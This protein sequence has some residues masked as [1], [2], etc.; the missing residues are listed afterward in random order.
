MNPG[1]LIF[2]LL[3]F[4][5]V[6]QVQSQHLVLPPLIEE[7]IEEIVA[8]ADE[9]ADISVIIDDLYFL[10][11]NPLDLNQAG[12]EDLTRL[13]LLNDFQIA[14]LFEYVRKFGPVLSIFE[15]NY[16]EGFDPALVLKIAPF[17]TIGT[18]PA[19]IP[20][21]PKNIL[22]YGRHQIY[23]RIQQVLEEQR[24]YLPISDSA[25]AASPNSR[26]L[27]SP[28][29]IY[30]RYVFS[31]RNQVFWGITAE[32]D[33]G[34]E[35]FKGSNQGGYD[36]Y[37]AH[38]YIRSSGK[39]KRIA[40]GDYHARF[41]QGLVL[42]PGFSTGKTADAVNIKKN[43]RGLIR[44]SSTDENIFMRGAAATIG[45]GS[46]TDIT[47]FISRKTI[48]ATIL[49][50]DSA[51]NR[52]SAV[53]S[54]QNTGL[55]ATQSQ[56]ANKNSLGETIAGTNISWKGETYRSGL[57]ALYYTYDAPLLPA[58]RVYNQYEFKGK[59]NLVA[60]MDYRLYFRN[61]HFF[62]E[63]AISR[64]GGYGFLNGMI[65]N[66][67]PRAALAMMYRKYSKN[68]QSYFSN[69]L[70]ESTRNSNETGL[71]TGIVLLP[72]PKW[73]VSGFYDIFYFPWLR[74][75]AFTPTTGYEYLLL[76]EY[77]PARN[78]SMWWRIRQ[79]NKPVNA[80]VEE[81]LARQTEEVIN[82]SYR[83]QLNYRILSSLELR[84]RIEFVNYK[85][86]SQPA[87]T[88]FLVYQDV[89]FRLSKIPLSLSARLA[90]FETD[91]YNA[92]MYA[93]ENDVLYA[94]SIPAYYDRGTRSYINLSYSF[95]NGVDLWF[96]IA[97]T[98]LP[99]RT[100]IGSGLDEISGRTRTEVKLQA[101]ITF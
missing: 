35:F 93:Y 20:L 36:Y 52:V 48:D 45:I 7:I 29:K 1:R 12:V 73:K 88:G 46:K 53:S 84:N 18:G 101:R 42:W 80:P 38:L 34:E 10:W 78:L 40:I 16:I 75:G 6:D 63:G 43:A 26:Y 17:F 67:G 90:V 39:V 3:I 77:T 95:P 24:G 64:N 22:K 27:G 70:G 72:F 62:G 56:V 76:A 47:L 54:L 96:R 51:S 98:Y 41:G 85:R 11:E 30:N 8:S 74:F 15:L 87:E 25:L 14:H 49:K 97:Q 50:I 2:I 99:Y 61:L 23:S 60:G 4:F 89:I 71:Y 82:T 31:Y 21:Y 33:A 55:H 81:P 44:Y 32:K 9:D 66:A 86:E 5:T 19:R 94:F 100:V 13:Y 79:K 91:S 65:A 59:S 57:T 68:Y 69:S 58:K 28:L 92:R 37:S 83:Y